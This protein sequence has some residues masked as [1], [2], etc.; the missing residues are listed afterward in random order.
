MLDLAFVRANQPLVEEKLRA[1]GMDPAAVM[2]DFTTIDRELRETI[3]SLENVRQIQNALSK[4]FGNT[5]RLG[6]PYVDLSKLRQLLVGLGESEAAARLLGKADQDGKLTLEKFAE[7]NSE[8]KKNEQELDKQRQTEHEKLSSILQS[9][10]NLPQDSVPVGRDEHANTVEKIW[11]GGEK[12][13]KSYTPAAPGFTPLPH[14]AIGER[15]GILV[16][17]RAA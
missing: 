1:R 11:D 4:E 8:N 13:D 14:W 12:S 9:L 10:P 16:F 2:Y 3:T 15:L 6:L 17:V 7:Q 5:K